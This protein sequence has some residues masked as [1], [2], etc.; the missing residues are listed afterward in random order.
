H[1]RPSSP[2]TNPPPK[3]PLRSF[4]PSPSAGPPGLRNTPTATALYA[5]I[6][7]LKVLVEAKSEEAAQ[8]RRELETLRNTAHAG[9]LAAMLREARS[10]AGV[11]R[12]RAQWAEAKLRELG[13][14]AVAG[15]ED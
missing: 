7:R 6:R 5:E 14:G 10:D 9:A 13:V 3:S 11:W 15:A 4:S 1:Q 12:N 8:T 2:P